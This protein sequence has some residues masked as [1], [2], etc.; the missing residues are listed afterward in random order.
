MHIGDTIE[1][2]SNGKF[3]S[4]LHRG[5]VN[6]EKVRISWAV[7]CEPPKE[8]IILKP[9][10]ETV[11]ETEPLLFPPRSFAQLIQHKLFKKS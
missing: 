9:L 7:F 4:I 6:K 2:L 3:K 11:S 10:P 5:L 1:I 8:K